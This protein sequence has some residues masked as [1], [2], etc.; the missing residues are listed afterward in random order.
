MIEIKKKNESFL[1]ISGDYED[2]IAISEFFT[3]YAPNFRWNPKF[4]AGMWDGKIRFFNMTTG[5][6]PYGLYSQLQECI[7]K[8]RIET[9]FKCNEG[10]PINI[11]VFDSIVKEFTVYE[12]Y[13]HQIEGA[14]KAIESRR[15]LLAHA[16]SS[17]KTTTLFLILKYFL[18]TNPNSKIVVVVP[19]I[20]LIQQF[21]SDF[22][23]YGMDSKKYI[24]KYFK[25][26]KD[27]TKQI[28][29]GTW[30]SLK[31]LPKFLETTNIVIADEVHNGKALEIKG[32]FE[33][34][35]NADVRIGVTGSLPKDECDLLTI[36]GSF[37]PILHTITMAELIKLG[38]VV[39][40][41]IIQIN[42]HYPKDV[43]KSCSKDYYLERDIIQNDRRRMLLVR[44]LVEV[45]PNKE[46]LL[47]LF[48]ELDFGKRYLEFLKEQFPERVFYYVDGDI[49]GDERESIRNL[50][51]INENVV[52]VAS[53]GTFSTG[54][55]IPRL[56]AIIGL[57][58]GK[59][60]IRL[61]Q[62]IGRGARKHETKKK[63][64]FYD[65]SDQLKF[66]K[67]HAGERL[68]V[69]MEEGHPVK[70]IEVGK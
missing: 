44:K 48:D 57:W 5:S 38:I 34:C 43:K 55:N 11:E 2:M 15:G 7:K 62:C 16:T 37:G 70:S 64:L 14:K 28:T 18:L 8:H 29:V 20:G 13:D 41:D 27:L 53:L 23:F 67:N 31:E 58:L 68:K 47:L 21:V 40:I 66:S 6:L 24:G 10:I 22:E 59:S 60:A 49:D 36:M 1:K 30:Q 9:D 17:G 39:P 26:E 65:I 32:V 46:N 50:A 35:I 63:L 52:I 42:F 12:P 51:T 56:H 69:Y 61:T 25:D 3:R 19:S 54:I 4:K 33:H 45:Q